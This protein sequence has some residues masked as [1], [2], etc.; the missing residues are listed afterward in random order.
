MF[1][2]ACSGDCWSESLESGDHAQNVTGIDRLAFLGDKPLD[3]AG[4]GRTD[5]ILHLHGLHDEDALAGLHLVTCIHE[6]ANHFSGHRGSDLLAAFGFDVTVAAAPPRA[7]VN[8]FSDEFFLTGLQDQRSVGLGRDVNSIGFAIEKDR[9]EIRRN[10]DGVS[11][12]RG[13]VNDDAPTIGV[14]VELD[15]ASCPRDEDFQL[16]GLRSSCSRRDSSFQ[17]DVVSVPFVC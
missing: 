12:N 16:H 2:H 8:D 17:R 3:C 13:T 9:E 4:L 15:D 10:F 5:F 11:V 7:R 6:Q 1:F 14:S